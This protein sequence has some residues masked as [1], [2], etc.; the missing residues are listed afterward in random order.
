[1]SPSKFISDDGRS[2]WVQA[3]WFVGV[4]SGSP[5]Y[6]FS[7]RKVL[8]EAFE[9]SAQKNAPDVEA[10]PAIA[11]DG[12]MPIEK[13]AHFGHGDVYNDGTTD[14]SEDSFGRQDK[15]ADSRGYT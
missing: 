4:K 2:M 8:V 14:R 6:N 11:G 1:M 3:N 7:L 12:V 10:D 5:N 15:V 13:A 9:P